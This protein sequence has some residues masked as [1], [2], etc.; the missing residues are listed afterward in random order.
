MPHPNQAGLA[1]KRAVPTSIDRASYAGCRLYGWMAS[2]YT[3]KVRSMLSYKRLPFTDVVPSAMQ[4]RLAVKPAVGRV[5]MPAVRLGDGSWRQDSALIC[6]EVERNHP[7]RPTRP[8]GATQRLAASLL[9]LHADEWLPMVALHYRWNTGNA[10]WAVSEFGRCAFPMLPSLIAS[11]LAQPVA[12]RMRALCR[13]HGA[14]SPALAGIESFTERLIGTLERHLAAGSAAGGGPQPYLLGGVPCRAD[15][16]LY[17]PLWAHLYRDPHSRAMFDGAP[18]VVRWFE[19]LHGHA[20]DAAF[21]QLAARNAAAAPASTSPDSASGSAAR[22]LPDD[23]VPETLDPLFRAL[24]DEQW[25]FLQL[26]CAAVD[27]HAAA[28]PDAARTPRA[29]GYAPFVAG[30]VAGERRLLAY[31]AWRAQRPLDEYWGL[32]LAPSRELE[33]RRVD[34]WLARLG[35]RDAFR[36]LQPAVRLERDGELPQPFDVLRPRDGRRLPFNAWH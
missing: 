8:P 24:F 30:G 19:R 15:F 17:G 4:L 22:F 28:H 2:P 10:D 36:A 6:D 11:R 23:E 3:A 34:A 9:E 31:S 7:D 16:A 32:A 29:F 21:P 1:F 27:E 13:V 18:H 35:V 33:L 14:V 25:P 26:A 20:A 5:I 12:D